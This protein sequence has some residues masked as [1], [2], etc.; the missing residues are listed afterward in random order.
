MNKKQL[1][2]ITGD[3]Y[4]LLKKHIKNVAVNFDAGEIHQFRVA[5]K[6]LRAFLRLINF[7]DKK[8]RAIKICKKLKKAYGMAG[9]IR[10]LQ[11]QQQRIGEAIAADYKRPQ[12][13]LDRLQQAMNMLKPGFAETARNNPVGKC[14]KK[15]D[16]GIPDEF[17]FNHF[18]D[19]VK[20]KW[21][22]VVT[23]TAYRHLRDDHIHTIRKHLKD[24]FYNL[25]IFDESEGAIISQ[26]I[27][28]EKDEA[29]YFQLL[30]ELGNFQDT[31]MAISFLE[32]EWVNGLNP[33]NHKLLAQVKKTWMKKKRQLKQMLVKKLGSGTA[34]QPA[35]N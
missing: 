8:S 6:K 22:S 9:S 18:S 16:A 19:F 10:D 27:W 23:I 5:Y 12:D 15:T 28:K 7:G 21:E 25:K 3:H 13:Y 35:F 33:Y 4:R 2:H 14:K 11:L 1:K 34:G 30:D 29:Y 32:K 26:G 24:L 20:Q 31:C 17:S